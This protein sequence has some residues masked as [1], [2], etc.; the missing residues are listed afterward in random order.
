MEKVMS[1]E[2]SKNV[3]R[4]FLGVVVVGMDAPVVA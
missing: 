2:T 3:G 1:V 4:W